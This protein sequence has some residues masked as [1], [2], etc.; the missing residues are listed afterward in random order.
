MMTHAA[1]HNSIAPYADQTPLSYAQQ[2]NT[3]EI[4][5]AAS[6]QNNTV[7]NTHAAKSYMPVQMN[8]T[9]DSGSLM[10]N[11]SRIHFA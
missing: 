11:I 8:Q 2:L 4:D 5:T 6:G 3:H 1:T 9:E 7:L 10:T